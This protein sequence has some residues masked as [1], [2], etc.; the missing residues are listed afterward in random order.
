MAIPDEQMDAV[1]LLL[2]EQLPCA[3]HPF[4][5]IGQRVR[6]RGGAMDG[7]EGVLLAHNGDRTLIVSVD[8]IQRSLAVRI[9]G[10]HVEPL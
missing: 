6:I 9:E 3:A 4:L 7:V 2:A 5:K 8:V 10:Y 1:R